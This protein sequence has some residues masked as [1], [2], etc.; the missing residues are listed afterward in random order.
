MRRMDLLRLWIEKPTNT[1]KDGKI[2]WGEKREKSHGRQRSGDR[3]DH[4]KKKTNRSKR[5]WD[6]LVLSV[7]SSILWQIVTN[8]GWNKKRGEWRREAVWVSLQAANK[9]VMPLLHP[10]PPPVLCALFVYVYVCVGIATSQELGKN[11]LF[12]AWQQLQF[13]VCP[14]GFERFSLVQRSQNL[15]ILQFQLIYKNHQNWS[16]EVFAWKGQYLSLH[17]CL[18]MCVQ[19]LLVAVCA[20]I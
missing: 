20:C 13:P 10:G 18:Y 14:K 5:E 4:K 6:L 15:F 16:W 3:V 7:V 19:H 8:D 1:D 12:I 2:I 9:E 17:L 11:V